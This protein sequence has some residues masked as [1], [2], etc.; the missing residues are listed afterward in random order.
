M[1]TY[2]DI[3]ISLFSSFVI[4]MEKAARGAIEEDRSSSYGQM[5]KSSLSEVNGVTSRPYVSSSSWQQRDS[6]SGVKQVT[7]NYAPESLRKENDNGIYQIGRQTY[8]EGKLHEVCR[9]FYSNTIFIYL[10]FI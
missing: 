1:H 7:D 9:L 4:D 8:L 10:I 5:F 3:N 2:I 6:S